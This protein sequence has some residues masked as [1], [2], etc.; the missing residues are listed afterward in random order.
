MVLRSHGRRRENERAQAR[1]A[2]RVVRPVA[3]PTTGH[4]AGDGDIALGPTEALERPADVAEVKGPE[5]TAPT[6]EAA[7]PRREYVGAGVMG[8]VIALLVVGAA[9]VVLVAQNSHPVDAS[10]LWF[11][12]RPRLSVLLLAAIV[13]TAIVTELVG[14]IWR[15]RRRR[16]RS[17]RTELE[18][19]RRRP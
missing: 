4:V 16:A 1:A 6:A 19:L 11:D 18:E 10:F 12:G 9:V 7:A 15:H 2:D 5:A 8:G 3:D 13:G 17:M 14:V